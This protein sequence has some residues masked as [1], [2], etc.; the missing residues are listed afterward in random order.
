MTYPNNI[1]PLTLGFEKLPWIRT[2]ANQYLC[3]HVDRY[4][5]RTKIIGWCLRSVGDRYPDLHDPKQYATFRNRRVDPMRTIDWIPGDYSE[6][7]RHPE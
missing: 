5:G 1:H 3:W 2:G 6:A 4:D 7:M